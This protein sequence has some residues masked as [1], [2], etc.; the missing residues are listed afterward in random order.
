[1]PRKK[2]GDPRS[3]VKKERSSDGT[4][5]STDRER[6]NNQRVLVKEK[7]KQKILASGE[8][9]AKGGVKKIWHARSEKA[10]NTGG[11]GDNRFVGGGPGR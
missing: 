8:K 10:K 7:K 1:M 5:K 11:E 4:I 6:L 9:S 3:L 2:G